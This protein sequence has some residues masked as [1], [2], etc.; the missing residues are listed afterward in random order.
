MVSIVSYIFSFSI[1]KFKFD[2][3][4]MQSLPA[5]ELRSFSLRR[6]SKVHLVFNISNHVLVLLPK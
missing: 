3:M 5:L 2:K 6:N 1:Y 4:F